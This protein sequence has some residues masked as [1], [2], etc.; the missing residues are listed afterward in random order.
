LHYQ[1]TYDILILAIHKGTESVHFHVPFLVQN[2]QAIKIYFE[3]GVYMKE[4]QSSQQRKKLV[5]T[6]ESSFF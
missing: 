2:L 1:N 4:V 3:S 6:K 5:V